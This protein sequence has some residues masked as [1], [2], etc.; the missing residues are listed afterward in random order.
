MTDARHYALAAFA[1]AVQPWID[2]L[3]NVQVKLHSEAGLLARLTDRSSSFEDRGRQLRELLPRSAS[4]E[5]GNF[6]LTLMERGDLGQLAA[7]VDWMGAMASAGPRARMAIVTTAYRLGDA[8]RGRFVA[9]LRQT[10]GD[11]LGISFSVDSAIVGGAVVRIGDRI[12]DGSVRT[13]LAAIDGAL[14]R[15]E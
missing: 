4:A 12:I 14:A 10:H 1:T 8:E 6:L 9:T 2:A 3:R 7:I 5:C 11:D 15:G 13:K